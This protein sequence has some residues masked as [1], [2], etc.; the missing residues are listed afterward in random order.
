MQLEI[1]NNKEVLKNKVGEYKE[2]IIKSFLLTSSFNMKADVIS[3]LSLED[4]KQIK[5][6]LSQTDINKC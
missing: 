5:K 6:V 3:S 4:T 2:E 1:E